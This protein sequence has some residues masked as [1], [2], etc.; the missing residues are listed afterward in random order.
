L[1]AL[2][3]HV[4][5]D[6]GD[7]LRPGGAVPL[8]FDPAAPLAPEPTLAAAPLTDLAD[9]DV[10]TLTGDNLR[11]GESVGIVVCDSPEFY[12][13]VCQVGTGGV[14]AAVDD[15]GHL[16]APYRATA[17]FDTLTGG[18]L[19]CRRQE[20]YLQ[21]L[22]GLTDPTI[23]PVAF[24]PDSPLAPPPEAF[25][26]V[27]EGR[28]LHVQGEGFLPGEEV[29]TGVC[30]KIGG[31]RT[32][33]APTPHHTTADDDGAIDSTFTPAPFDGFDTVADCRAGQCSVFFEGTA[34][35]ST[36][37]VRARFALDP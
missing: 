3:V 20:C 27:V 19:D 24:E 26:R 4:F 25:V 14:P 34:L 30:I 2:S 23:V 37:T 7:P 29:Y 12:R 9:G 22:P 15:D 11:P 35:S 6:A 31:E 18:T 17:V 5:D 1:C 33:Q 10:V 13:E 16:S 32:C 8:G 21:I 28:D 36:P